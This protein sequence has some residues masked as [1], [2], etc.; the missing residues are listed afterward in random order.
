MNRALHLLFVLWLLSACTSTA[1]A[2]SEIAADQPALTIVTLNLYHD[3][4]DWPRRR[5]QIVETLRALQPDAI[6]LQEVLQHDTLPNQA[7]WLATQLDY[8]WHFVSVDPPGAVRRYGN[9]LLTRLPVLARDEMKLHPYEDSRTVA[10]LRVELQGK[11]V[12]L[13]ATHLHHT[14]HGGAMRA[15]QL[16][17]V[18]A[19][20]AR[21]GDGFPSVVA[22]D[23]NAAAD[24]PELTALHADFVDTYGYIHPGADA[25]SSSTLNLHYFEPGRIDHVFHQ[26]NAFKPV[27]AQIIL[28]HADA[29]GTWPSDHYGLQV[30]LQLIGN[31]GGSANP[32]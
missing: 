29:D 4:D 21:T 20:I 9:A 16:D 10:L 30:E 19:F 28:D 5:V 15:Q 13:Y 2:G 32:R 8:D 17:D 6:A 26:R 31:H 12:N 23:F 11:P 3:K 22:G 14:G 18:M 25:R 24:A 27:A 7:E 1:P